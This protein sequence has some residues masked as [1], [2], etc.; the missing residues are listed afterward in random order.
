MSLLPLPVKVEFLLQQFIYRGIQSK[1]ETRRLAHAQPPVQIK[2]P[3]AINK[4]LDLRTAE[5]KRNFRLRIE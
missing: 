5:L 1:R 3:R 4:K 2:T